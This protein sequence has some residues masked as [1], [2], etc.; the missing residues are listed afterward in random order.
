MGKRNSK[1]MKQSYLAVQCQEDSEGVFLHFIEWP[2]LYWTQGLGNNLCTIIMIPGK[3]SSDPDWKVGWN[4][5][6]STNRQRQEEASKITQNRKLVATW[7]LLGCNLNFNWR[8]AVHKNRT[9]YIK[10]NPDSSLHLNAWTVWSLTSWTAVR[11]RICSCFF[12]CFRRSQLSEKDK[13]LCLEH[14]TQIIAYVST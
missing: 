9:L 6:G 4:E 8:K 2:S 12:E 14:I 10:A 7:I 5:N 11:R 3:A 1:T 13:H